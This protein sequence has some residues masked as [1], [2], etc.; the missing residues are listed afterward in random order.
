L[1]KKKKF[2]KEKQQARRSTHTEK[3][4]AIPKILYP[5][6]VELRK[7]PPKNCGKK[8]AYLRVS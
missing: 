8:R 2:G 5:E 4:E 6:I 7:T 3:E 1:G